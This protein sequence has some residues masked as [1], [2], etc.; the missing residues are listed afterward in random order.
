MIYKLAK[1]LEDAGFPSGKENQDYY[2]EW[3]D[4]IEPT[5]NELIEA[6]GKCN[7]IL[8]DVETHWNA[9]GYSL[10]VYHILQGKTPE[11]AVI[12]LWLALNIKEPK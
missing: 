8:A 2:E 12:K 5:L 4:W 10:N 6:C 3:R 1:Q 11:E 9:S 7:F